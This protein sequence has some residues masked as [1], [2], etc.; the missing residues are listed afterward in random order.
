MEN[1]LNKTIQN[2][3]IS[4]IRQ[5]NQ[6]ADKI[7]GCIKFT[8]GEPNFN[9]DYTVKKACKKAIDKNMTHYSSNAGI[10]ELRK[11]IAD[12]VYLRYGTKYEKE[13]IIV[14]VGAS[15]ALSVVLRTIL[16]PNDQVIVFEPAY[17]A[18][19][20]LIEMFNAK[21][22][23]IDTCDD[24][25]QIM[26]K[27]LERC[28]TEKTKA[29][30][31][32]SP[33]NPTGV[34]Y[35][36]DSIN[37]VLNCIKDRDIFVVCDNIYDEIIYEDIPNFVTKQRERNKIIMTQSFSKSYAMAGY[38]LGYICADKSISRHLLK[39]HSYL[40]SGATTF[41]QYAGLAALNTNNSKMVEQYKKR[42]DY[43]CERLNQMGI[44]ITPPQGAFYL[45]INISQFQ[46]NS[47]DFALHL[48]QKYKVCV[49]PGRYFGEHCDDYIRISYACSDNDLKEGFDRIERFV[50]DFNN[51]IPR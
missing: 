48:L 4:G 7:E 40:V 50:N 8:L 11:K 19:R 6:M 28:I 35:H 1:R 36:N 31:L 21:Y 38:R 42:R 15:E 49:V 26:E 32:T 37:A 17:P 47:Y 45:F 2:L 39:T 18:Y 10:E 3:R 27:K 22:I 43:A 20:P 25:F 33:N 46:M 51:Q 5:F 24:E 14:T 41:V 16:N 9:S 44:S 30:L 13:E 34:A 23:G 29:I 12:D